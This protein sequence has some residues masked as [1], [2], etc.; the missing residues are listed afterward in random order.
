[1]QGLMSLSSRWIM[2]GILILLAAL[3]ALFIPLDWLRYLV[4]GLLAAAGCGLAVWGYR[5]AA[6]S[7]DEGLPVFQALSQGDLT[8]RLAAGKEGASSDIAGCCNTFLDKTALTLK[9]VREEGDGL[10]KQFQ[11]FKTDS[12]EASK[13]LAHLDELVLALVSKAVNHVASVADV[14]TNTD[15]VSKNNE[16]LN[17]LIESQA[18]AVTE[19]SAAIEEMTANIG[20]VTGILRK[21]TERME[22]LLHASEAGK[23]GIQKVTDIMRVLVQDSDGLLEASSMIQSIAQQ[24]NLLS[25]NAAIEAAH[26]GEVGKGFAVV[27]DEIR[28]LAENSSK[29]GKSISSVLTGLKNQI[30]NATE[31]SDASQGQ[32][33]AILGQIS[34]IQRQEEEIN[35]AM[36]EQAAGSSQILDAVRNIG[37]ITLEVKESSRQT[38]GASGSIL[39]QMKELDGETDAM[40]RIINDIMGDMDDWQESRRGIDVPEIGGGIARIRGAVSG[41]QV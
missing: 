13:M 20:S 38:K 25:M 28:K 7:T 19:S 27:A 4:T 9:T 12:E 32:I 31:I 15:E 26:A 5:E 1:M 23:E 40:S 34:E 21:N 33:S 24:T 37:E 3:A 8:R 2:L 18:A 22:Q 36:G 30:Y 17:R 14:Y 10:E 35:N 29:Q 41:F 16:A 11:K 6:S 39:K